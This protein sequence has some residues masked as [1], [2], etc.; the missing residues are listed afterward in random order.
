MCPTCQQLNPGKTGKVGHGQKPKPQRPFK[1]L[2]M[3]FIQMLSAIGY[4][5]IAVVFCLFLEWVK[6][7]PYWRATTL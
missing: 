4:E 3:D 2:Q 6:A 5:Y 7:F 1:H